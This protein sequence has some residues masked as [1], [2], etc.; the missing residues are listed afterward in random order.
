M[1]RQ[2][3]NNYFSN[4]LAQKIKNM[5]ILLIATAYNSL[6]QRAH[7]ELNALGHDVSVELSLN[8][9]IMKE[10][11]AL[12]Q[13][14]LILCPFMKEKIPEDIWRNHVCIII[15]PGIKGDRGAS[16]MDWAILN[17][18]KEWGVTALQAAETMDAGD[19]WASTTFKRK[20]GNKGRM[21]RNEVIEAGIKVILVTVKRFAS[22]IYVPQPL[23]Y[24]YE[25]VKGQL[26][27]LMKQEVR[28][29]DWTKD[30]VDTI[31]RKIDSA[32][33]QPGLLDTIYG[34]EYYL[35]GT[36]RE[37]R[38]L[39][40][41]G[42]IIAQRQGAICRATVDGAIWIS[43]LRKK[44][45][46]SPK[47]FKLPATMVLGDVLKDVPESSIEPF[48]QNFSKDFFDSFYKG[49]IPT[50]ND[51]WYV[52]ENEVGYLIFDFYNGAMDTAKCNRL[53][54][55]FLVARQRTTKVIVLL[56]NMDFWSNG[57]HLNVIEAAENPADEAWRNINAINDLVEAIIT[58]ETHLVISAMLGNASAGGLIMAL[59]ADFVFARDGIVLNPHYKAMGLYGSEYWTY[60]LPK[61]VGQEK[62]L[63][64]TENCLPISTAQA[65]TMKL[66]DGIVYS[67]GYD[68]HRHITQFAERLVYSSNYYK[69]LQNKSETRHQDEQKKA[70]AEYRAE[71][72]AE[73]K[74]CF[75]ES[76]YV[77]PPSCANF[78]IAR[79]NFV[80]KIRPL[81]TP[82]RIAK[83][84]T[85]NTCS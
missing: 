27:P 12:F 43:H 30:G 15:H 44:K 64:L 62:T 39:G 45:P 55:A 42:K 83:H 24:S 75:Y 63:E 73:M 54:E 81:A 77:Y 38:L 46:A 21:Y 49:A 19:I 14:D 56:S 61:R 57:I 40:Q 10:G 48:Q 74:K 68:F 9:Q 16:A 78:H 35:Y 11:I 51:I 33:N 29:I 6:T 52:E 76:D 70:L 28:R 41:P 65:K 47:F 20:P 71:E 25:D 18:E 7:L 5:R 53:K 66:I 17:D 8:N 22:G 67:D 36:H 84:R 69:Q 26:R 85:A 23:D 72:L 59:A 50:Y 2:C 60:L 13:P 32:D 37:N 58:T 1:T 79:Y 34:Q 82:L 31:I 4:S 80:H 3:R